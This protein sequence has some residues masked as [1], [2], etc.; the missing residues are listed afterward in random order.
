MD[1]TKFY[2]HSFNPKEEGFN[3]PEYDLFISA[4]D[5]C[6]RTRIPYDRVPAKQK[7]W[8]LFPQYI[9]KGKKPKERCYMGSGNRESEY[10]RDFFA[11][12]EKIN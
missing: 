9:Y 11:S 10:F 5:E 2:K 6:D 3:Y 12:F 8:M 1:F 4:Y 7:I